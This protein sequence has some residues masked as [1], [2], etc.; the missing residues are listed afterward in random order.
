MGRY[1]L[2]FRIK[3]TSKSASDRFLICRYFFFYISGLDWPK[4]TIL[5]LKKT[6]SNVLTQKHFHLFNLVEIKDVSRAPGKPGVLRIIR[7]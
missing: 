2:L 6:H 5:L 4:L 3:T 1:I 7:R